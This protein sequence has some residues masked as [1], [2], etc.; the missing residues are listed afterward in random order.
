MIG[1]AYFGDWLA[2][3]IIVGECQQPFDFVNCPSGAALAFQFRHVL[4]CY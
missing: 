4:V 3:E 2:P 1:A